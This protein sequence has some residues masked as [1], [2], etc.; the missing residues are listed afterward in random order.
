MHSIF[1]KMAH[2]AKSQATPNKP[3]QP[4]AV[5]PNPKK[6]RH[7]PSNINPTDYIYGF[8][9]WLSESPNR[10]YK[11]GG[12]ESQT[13]HHTALARFCEENNLPQL[14]DDW[15]DKV[16]KPDHFF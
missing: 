12:A 14:S 11:I 13:H 3:K 10:V 2:R 1:E 4:E 5:A 8:I 9:F 7:A 16:K 15:Q 6:M